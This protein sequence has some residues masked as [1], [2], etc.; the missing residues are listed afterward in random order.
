MNLIK[1]KI[2]KYLEVVKLDLS[3]VKNDLVDLMVCDQIIDFSIEDIEFNGCKFINVD[4][5]KYPLKN[6]SFIDCIFEKCNLYGSSFIEKGIN[7]TKF[8]RCNMVGCDFISCNFNDVIILNS[9]CDYINFSDSKMKHFMIQDTVVKE[10]R[11]VSVKLNDINFNNVDFS[12]CE[13]LNTKLQGIDFSNCDINNISVSSNDIK[14]I[15]VN[16]TQAIMLVS[17]LGIIIK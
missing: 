9:K 13:F 12:N 11:F 16:E 2:S 3:M 14:G 17:L 5:S 6:I 10:G 15:I 8:D 7:R 4:F 1:P